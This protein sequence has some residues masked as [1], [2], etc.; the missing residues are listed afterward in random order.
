MIPR[1]I[2]VGTLI[3]FM[4]F[5]LLGVQETK[6]DTA[7]PRTAGT[8]SGTNWSNPGNTTISDDARAIYNST[9][10]NP[11]LLT[12]FGFT[13]PAGA[14][15][16]GITVTREGGGDGSNVPRRRYQMALMKDG[17]NIAGTEKTGLNLPQTTEDTVDVGSATDLWGTTWTS[18]E[19]NSTNFGVQIRDNDTTAN[20]IFFDYIAVTITY[21]PAGGIITVG[22]TGT[23]VSTLSSGSVNQFANSLT[24][25]SAS[26]CAAFTLSLDTGSDTITSIKVTE[27]GTVA[28]NTDLSNLAL[29]YDTNGNWADAETETQFGS[30]VGTFTSE[31]ATVSGSLAISSGVTYYFYVRSDLKSGTPTYPKGGQTIDFDISANGDVVVS[32]SSLKTGA[33]VSLAGTITVLPDAI[34]V[35]IN[36]WYNTSWAYRK[37]NHY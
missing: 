3:L 31:T 37:K 36:N 32:G 15:I 33:P 30:T 22:S 35:T 14:T 11:L 16:N 29:F 7:G 4:I 1:I 13:I 24:C 23:Q 9:A 18:T 10:Q 2:F 12:N 5:I 6:A 25:T 27:T 26:T 28:A 8:A 21:T 17:S 34:T 19:I 20:G